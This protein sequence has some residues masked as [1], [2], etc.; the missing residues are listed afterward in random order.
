MQGIAAFPQSSQPRLVDLHEPSAPAAGQVLCRT[1]QLGICGT[2]RE[3]LDSQQPH[4]PPGEPFLVLGHECLARV[5][6]LGALSPQQAVCLSDRLTGADRGIQVGDL[7]VPVVRRA[8]PQ[9]SRRRVDMLAVGQFTERGIFDAHGFS[10]PYWSDEPRYLMRVPPELRPFAVL[11][12]PVAVA[13]KGVNE[14]LLLQQARLESDIWTTTPP[15]VLVTGMGPIAFA[16]A[17][18]ARARQWPCAVYGRDPDDSPRARL[19]RDL[20]ADYVHQDQFEVAPQTVERDGYDLI[21]EC[22]G[23]ESVV[24]ATAPALR[25][26]GVM[27]WLGSRRNPQPTSC[28]LGRLIRDGLIRNNLFIGCVNAAPRDFAEALARLE[29][30]RRRSSPLLARMMTDR[31]APTAAL[32]HFAAR[33]RDSI[34]TVIEYPT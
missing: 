21:L 19:T 12:E 18:V 15:R 1:L 28:N 33:R 7:V 32:D 10:V 2:D 8:L 31:V 4:C 34:K 20:G 5:E 17:L 14:A 9:F 3:I 27:V 30:W 26:C 25:S 16:A 23:A 29:D 22:T 6:S 11:T 13:A 24:L